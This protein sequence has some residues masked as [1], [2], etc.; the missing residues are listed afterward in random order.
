MESPVNVNDVTS[1]AAPGKNSFNF[2]SRLLVRL[3]LILHG[4]PLYGVSYRMV[5]YVLNEI[6]VH[7]ESLTYSRRL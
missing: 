1:S 5:L 6:F 4:Q 7:N 2:I 3:C